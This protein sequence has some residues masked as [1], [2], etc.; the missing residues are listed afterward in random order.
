MIVVIPS[1][2]YFLLYSQARHWLLL[3]VTVLVNL[4]LMIYFRPTIREEGLC[5]LFFL[6]TNN[7]TINPDFTHDH[8]ISTFVLGSLYALLV[9][10]M[11]LEHFIV[12]W[13]HFV[14]PK[15]PYAISEWLQRHYI[16][17]RITKYICWGIC[18]LYNVPIILK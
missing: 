11:I 4:M 12:T 6:F 2:C 7:G 16:S 10:W 13:P 3:L 9:I 15:F 17:S 18:P 5:P 8:V 14:L 1:A